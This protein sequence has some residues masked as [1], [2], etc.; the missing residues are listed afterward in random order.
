MV[1]PFLAALTVVF[2]A[3]LGDKTQLATLGLATRYPPWKVLLGVGLGFAVVTAL[4]VAVGGAL[5]RA[6]PG[7]A[8]TVAAGVLFLGFA[9]RELW[10]LRD[11]DDDDDEEI[12][13]RHTRSV[14]L[15][16]AV[17]IAIAEL[18]DKTQITAAALAA[19]ESGV[20]LVGVWAGATLGELGACALA[21]GAGHLLSDRLTPRAVHVLAA[22]AFGLAGLG[23]LA[24]LAF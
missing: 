11:L 7:D 5:A 16:A 3:E 20:G 6:V 23:T 1:A 17:T 2:L 12:V 24:T 18:G 22:S 15:T 19:R 14:V 9:G 21:V 10:E 13:E 4:G 8:L